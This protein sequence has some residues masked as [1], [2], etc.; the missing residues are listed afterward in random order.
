[1]ASD[2][3]LEI[4]RAVVAFL[5]DLDP[6]MDTGMLPEQ[7]FAMQPAPAPSYPFVRYGTPT[8]IPLRAT[9]VDGGDLIVAIHGFSAGIEDPDDGSLVETAEMHAGRMG[10]AIAENIH[11]KR[12]A[13]DEGGDVK[14]EWAGSTLVPDSAEA[15]V[16]HAIVN[17]RARALI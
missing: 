8:I 6:L 7:V 12:L 14:I 1:M 15:G 2:R 17:I 3:T 16:Y 5:K 10:K 13:L 9:G 4:R 11:G